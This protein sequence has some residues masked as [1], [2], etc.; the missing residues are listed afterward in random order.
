MKYGTVNMCIFQ[1]KEYT[2]YMHIHTELYVPTIFLN[3]DLLT[4][5]H[6]IFAINIYKQGVERNVALLIQCKKK[7]CGTAIT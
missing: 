3:V 1:R 4:R 6:I 2:Q 7:H 5:F